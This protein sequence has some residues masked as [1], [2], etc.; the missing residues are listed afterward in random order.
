MTVPLPRERT[1]RKFQCLLRPGLRSSTPALLRCP[2][3]YTGQP[4]SVGEVSTW[5]WD[6]L[7][8]ILGAVIRPSTLWELRIRLKISIKC[9]PPRDWREAIKKVTLGVF[10]AAAWSLWGPLTHT[11]D[12]GLPAPHSPLA[13]RFSES[14]LSHCQ[15]GTVPTTSNTYSCSKK[16]SDFPLSKPHPRNT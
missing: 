13:Q 5:S 8:C 11:S 1:R 4:R 6:S 12:S 15:S 10:G 16:N 9:I 14:G 3:S 2:V 7:G